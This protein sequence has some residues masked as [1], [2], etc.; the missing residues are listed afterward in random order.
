M[1][2]PKNNKI[3]RTVL[4]KDLKNF[5]TR[6][7]HK[8]SLEKDL[9][10]YATLCQFAKNLSDEIDKIENHL[11]QNDKLDRYLIKEYNVVIE[12]ESISIEDSHIKYDVL[13][14]VEV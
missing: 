3:P 9:K 2:I 13:N 1:D 14:I 7:F 8:S 4:D 5:I 6:R 12:R 11:I 10:I